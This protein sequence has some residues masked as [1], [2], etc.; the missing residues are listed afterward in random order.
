MLP[1]VQPLKLSGMVFSSWSFARDAVRQEELSKTVLKQNE[2]LLD[3]SR[4]LRKFAMLK[5]D[6]QVEVRQHEKATKC[7]HEAEGSIRR[8][9]NSLEVCTV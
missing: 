8:L 7:L 9:D 6:H 3:N 5:V 2:A 1:P 4:E